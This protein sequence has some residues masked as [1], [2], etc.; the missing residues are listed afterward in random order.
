MWTLIL[1]CCFTPFLPDWPCLY[2]CFAS[3]SHFQSLLMFGVGSSEELSCSMSCC[4]KKEFR[5]PHSPKAGT[6]CCLLVCV[7]AVK[8][9]G[10]AE[11]RHIVLFR[12]SCSLCWLPGSG[13]MERKRNVVRLCQAQTISLLL[14]AGWPVL[15]VAIKILSAASEFGVLWITLEIRPWLI[16]MLQR[17]FCLCGR[18]SVKLSSVGSGLGREK[19]LQS[20]MC[21]QIW[22]GMVQGAQCVLSTHL[23][24]DP[25]SR[26][27]PAWPLIPFSHTMDVQ[28]MA[29]EN[30]PVPHRAVLHAAPMDHV[31]SAD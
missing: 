11:P 26:R 8:H 18:S 16:S 19:S 17:E 29:Q 13:A 24:A 3:F 9:E 5:A 31:I 7:P 14:I 30:S 28:G 1:S 6:F 25:C 23:Q 4:R 12:N 10:M 22:L 20:L 27:G 2:W 21:P 15:E